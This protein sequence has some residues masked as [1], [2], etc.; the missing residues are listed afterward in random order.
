MLPQNASFLDIYEWRKVDNNIDVTV[1]EKQL[2]LVLLR[3]FFGPAQEAGAVEDVSE[4]NSLAELAITM[5]LPGERFDQLESQTSLA[6]GFFKAPHPPTLSEKIFL[7]KKDNNT[8]APSYFVYEQNQN[9]VFYIGPDFLHNEI[10]STVIN[11]LILDSLFKPVAS[12]TLRVSSQQV[13]NFNQPF[14]LGI[15]EESTGS[16]F[17]YTPV[18]VNVCSPFASKDELLRREDA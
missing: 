17:R 3:L 7:A 2:I 10:Q 16:F 11:C 14:T 9:L 13:M 12:F 8:E 6:R 5:Q 18:K 15:E 4:P 1:G